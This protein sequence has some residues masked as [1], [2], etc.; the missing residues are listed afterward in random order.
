MDDTSVKTSIPEDEVASWK[1]VNFSADQ[2]NDWYYYGWLPTQA[3]EWR[4]VGFH[5]PSEADGWSARGFTALEA[6]AWYNAGFTDLE[7]DT[8]ELWRDTLDLQP[9]SAQAWRGAG[10]NHAQAMSWIEMGVELD[11]AISESSRTGN[12]LHHL[13]EMYTKYS[14]SESSTR[15]YAFHNGSTWRRLGF[16]PR[17]AALW[18]STGLSPEQASDLRDQAQLSAPKPRR[19]HP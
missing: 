10:F 13:P 18:S 9:G 8:P 3:S 15:D 6:K 5:D 14:L 11:E 17:G 7:A 12:K 19:L 2:A 1:A 4:K 16:S